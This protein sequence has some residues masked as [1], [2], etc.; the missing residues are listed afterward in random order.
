[1]ALDGSIESLEKLESNGVELYIDSN[2][3]DTLQQLG[4]LFVDYVTRSFGGGVCRPGRRPRRWLGLRL[5]QFLLS[6]RRS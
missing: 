1:M 5:M 4:G 3:K 2:L 6:Y